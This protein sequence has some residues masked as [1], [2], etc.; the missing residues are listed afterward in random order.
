MMETGEM[1]GRDSARAR[2]VGTVADHRIILGSRKMW[3]GD[4]HFSW[5]YWEC[6]PT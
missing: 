4:F 2:V 1:R 5:G 6:D 3:G